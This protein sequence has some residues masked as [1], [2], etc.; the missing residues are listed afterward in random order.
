MSIAELKKRRNVRCCGR[1]G[2]FLRII[3]ETP[4]SCHSADVPAS[5]AHSTDGVLIVARVGNVPSVGAVA[6]HDAALSSV[7][8]TSTIRSVESQ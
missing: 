4:Q 6:S 2:C 5:A 1:V 8:E 3:L 7:I